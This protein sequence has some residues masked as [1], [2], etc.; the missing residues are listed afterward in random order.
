MRNGER[1]HDWNQRAKPPQWDDEAE[2]EEQMIGP[3]E[4]MEKPMLDKRQGRLAP[5]R[6]EP[7]Q[8]RIAWQLERTH[9]AARRKKPQYRDDVDPEPR[10]AGMN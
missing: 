10:D 4:D 8:A 7:Y 9:D 5:A 1:R 6:I 2:Q 3:V